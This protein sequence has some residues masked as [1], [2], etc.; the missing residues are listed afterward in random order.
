MQIGSHWV[1]YSAAFNVERSSDH[2]Y[3]NYKVCNYCCGSRY[4]VDLSS[5]TSDVFHY[6]IY[7]NVSQEPIAPVLM[8][9]FEYHTVKCG[10]EHLN[11][12]IRVKP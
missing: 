1:D 5:L 6:G 4:R 2:S 8:D 7:L 9:K 11:F 12:I 3:D 10:D